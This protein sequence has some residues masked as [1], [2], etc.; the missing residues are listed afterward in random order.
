[1]TPTRVELERDLK[2][3]GPVDGHRGTSTVGLGR[4]EG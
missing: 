3:P 4:N 1:M 2:F